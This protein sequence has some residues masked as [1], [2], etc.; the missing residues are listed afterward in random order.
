[1]GS[2]TDLFIYSLPV[3]SP[4]VAGSGGAADDT[5]NGDT[6]N[7]FTANDGIHLQALLLR[8]KSVLGKGGWQLHRRG[9]SELLR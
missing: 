9:D 4:F 1:M 2:G 3:Y 5:I 7:S 8:H 6:T